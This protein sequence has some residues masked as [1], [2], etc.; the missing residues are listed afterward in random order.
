MNRATF[1]KNHKC[2]LCLLMCLVVLIIITLITSFIIVMIQYC[3]NELY[4]KGK[5]NTMELFEIMRNGTNKLFN[6]N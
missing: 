4:L 3:N 1:I 5:N 6:S 2:C